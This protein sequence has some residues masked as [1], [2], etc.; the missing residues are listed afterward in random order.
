M[1]ARI[2]LLLSPVLLLIPAALMEAGNRKAGILTWIVVSFCVRALVRWHARQNNRDGMIWGYGALFLPFIVP[3]VLALLPQDPSSPGASL[4]ADH[5]GDRGKAAR[6]AFEER[7]P[8]LAHCLEGQPEATRVGMAAHFQK[9]KTNFEFLLPAKADAVAGVLAGAR[10]RGL[11]AWTGS[12]GNVPQIY[13][14]GMLR[15]SDVEQAGS[16]LATAGAPGG[17]LTIAYRDA[18]GIL[19][20]TEHRFEQA[21]GAKA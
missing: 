21:A 12:D 6:G 1:A 9:V 5:S 18:D 4:R 19:R 15:Q 20:F 17:K 8:L 3:V 16:W 11:I 13:G 2:L 10:S 14:A 7:F